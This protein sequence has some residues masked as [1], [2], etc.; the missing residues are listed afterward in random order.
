MIVGVFT[1]EHIVLVIVVI[2][3]VLLDKD[4][5]WVKLFKKRQQYKKEVKTQKQQ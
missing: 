1:I 3:R 2:L 4:P 5:A